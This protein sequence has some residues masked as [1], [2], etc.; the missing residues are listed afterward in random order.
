MSDSPVDPSRKSELE[1]MRRKK[2][3]HTFRHMRMRLSL[4]LL[5]IQIPRRGMSDAIILTF[6]VSV[7]VCASVYNK[8]DVSVPGAN[9]S[10]SASQ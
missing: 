2:N 6:S 9:H 8:N 5:D 1:I 7:F 4:Y 3:V 10:A